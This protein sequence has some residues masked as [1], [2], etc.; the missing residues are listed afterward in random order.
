MSYRFDAG[1]SNGTQTNSDN[2]DFGD[3]SFESQP[4]LNAPEDHRRTRPRTPAMT[5]ETDLE[6]A[7]PKQTARITGRRLFTVC[8]ILVTELCERLTYYSV[9]ANMVLF[10]T[11]KL[12]ISSDSASV[13]TLVFSG[14]VMCIPVVGGIIADSFAGKY[15]TILGAGLI[16]ILGLFL[17]PASAIDYRKWFGGDE[18]MS[19]GTRK[20][21]FFVGLVFVAIGTGGIKA[22]V[23]PFGAEQIKDLGPDA[24]QSFFNWFYWFI[25]AGAVVAYS[26]VAYVQQEVGF[27]YG[28]LIPLLSMLLA[29]VI[30]MIAKQ[31]YIHQPTDGSIV[32]QSCGVCCQSIN[33]CKN[34]SWRNALKENGGSYDHPMVEGVKAVL[35]VLPVFGI[36]IIYWAVYSQM[37]TS[38]FLQSERMD[39]TVNGAKLPAAILN[40]FN[41]LIILVMIPIMDRIVYPTLAKYGKSP[42]HLQRMGIGI[43]LVALSMV[44]A[45]IIEIIRKKDMENH[46]FISQELSGSTFNASKISMFA[47]VPEFALIGGSEV[48]ASIS[49][50]EF[51]YTQA[52]EFMQGLIMGLFLMTSGIGS[53]VASLIVTIVQS[54]RTSESS[55]WFP[56]EANDGHMEYMLF[57]LAVLSLLSLVAFIFVAKWYKYKQPHFEG[58]TVVLPPPYE[59]QSY[60][61]YDTKVSAALG[62]KQWPPEFDETS[63]L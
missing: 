49:G 63:R 22:N 13:I 53:Y 54:W 50:L 47:Q 38:L 33:K 5:K 46:G 52:P 43:F 61:S 20:T 7:R 48:F 29:I 59:N 30:F 41:T 27:D 32:A 55:D 17:L 40:I 12:K 37:S 28:F 45:G 57:L 24:V 23:G 15:N 19:L 56:E 8:S 25:N 18:D 34:P 9:V 16:Y 3:T 26:G 1:G 62:K 2:E 44:Y 60:E 6:E 51:A 36:V 58:E 14:T 35:K 4:L 31:K 11:D 10:C 21:Y 39:I 42:T